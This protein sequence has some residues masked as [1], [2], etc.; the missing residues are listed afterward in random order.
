MRGV[1]T[2]AHIGGQRCDHHRNMRVCSV[3]ADMTC[4]CVCVC[5]SG[6]V[7]CAY[8]TA[9]A[10]IA[11]LRMCIASNKQNVGMDP[12]ESDTHMEIYL[13]TV[14]DNITHTMSVLYAGGEN[15]HNLHDIDQS[16]AAYGTH[17]H[18]QMPYMHTHRPAYGMHARIHTHRHT[19]T[20]C[21]PT[22]HCACACSDP[23]CRQSVLQA[24]GPACSRSVQI[25]AKQEGGIH[26]LL[27][28]LH[29]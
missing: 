8:Y 10:H 6:C 25:C 17:A 4:M 12:L 7:R 23:P 15:H 24:V 19:C 14:Q 27:T 26:I 13:C 1:C 20:E 29:K 21:I 18:I 3:A 5:M 11:Y 16:G 2:H 9:P 28:C 22:A